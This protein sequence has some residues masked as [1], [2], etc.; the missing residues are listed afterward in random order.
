MELSNL[1]GFRSNLSM[2]FQYHHF[3]LSKYLDL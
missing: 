2:S 3:V 1:N